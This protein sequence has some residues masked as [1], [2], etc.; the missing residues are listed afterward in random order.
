[1]GVML[2]RATISLAVLAMSLFG[3]AEAYAS[4][5]TFTFSPDPPNEEQQTTFRFQGSTSDV[6]RIRWDMDGNGSFETGTGRGP[7]TVTRTYADPGPRTVRMRVTYDDGDE[8]ETV[9]RTFTVNAKPTPAFDFAPAEP[10]EGQEV[11]F[12]QQATDPEGD[13]MTFAW[14]FG[15]GASGSGASATHAYEDVGSYDVVL[16]ATDQH[17]AFATATRTVTVAADPGPTAGFE[18]APTAPMTDETVTFT[19]TSTPSQGSITGWEWDLDGDFDFDDASGPG[20]SWSY[21]TAGSYIVSLRATQANGRSSVAFSAVE[22]RQ[23]PP[24]EPAPP[25]D[26]SGSGNPI[27]GP[28]GGIVPPAER[29]TA[30]RLVRMRPFPVVRIAGVVLSR[31][32]LVQILSVRVPPGARVTVRCGGRSCPVGAVARTSATTKLLRFRRFERRL[33]AGTTLTLFVRKQGRIG[34]YT[35]FTIRAGKA[36]ARVD[37]CLVPGRKQPVRCA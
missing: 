13:A 3:G 16:T 11:V 10:L 19:S 8:V 7:T 12:S 15:D 21:A 6:D 9:T 20:V 34:K 29:P 23:R 32:A 2:R 18:F 37:R 30:R 25:Q 36:P 14:S 35:R 31:G 28:V 4:H 5:Y 17:G 24:D 22:V 33:A 27:T 26:T 1:M